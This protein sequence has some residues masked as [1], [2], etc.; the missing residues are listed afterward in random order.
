MRIIN[1]DGSEANMC[2]NGIRCFAKYVYENNMVHKTRIEVETFA[3]IIIPE[4]QIKDGVITGVKVN[5]GAPFL[6]RAEIPMKGNSGP[7][8]NEL[9]SV[10]GSNHHITSLLMGVPH[11]IVFADHVKG[12]DVKPVGQPIETHPV[13]PKKTNVDFVQVLNDHEIIVRTWERGAGATLACGTGCCASAVASNLNQKTGK[14]VTVH[15]QV[16]DLFIEWA[17]DNNVY[18]TGPA[19]TV[20]KGQIEI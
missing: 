6:D 2:G 9:L 15:L 13:F 14:K 12:M 7:V 20:F 5:M 1:S 8:I 17:D 19:A 18:M 10:N 11:T 16:G 3:G 4:L